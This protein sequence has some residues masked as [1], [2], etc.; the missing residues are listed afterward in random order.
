MSP[1]PKKRNAILI[2][3]GAGVFVVGTGLAAFAV[4]DSG[5]SSAPPPAVTTTTVADPDGVVAA[6]DAAAIA[7]P[8][9][10]PSG[11][12]AMSIQTSV[13]DG[14]SGYAKAGD[15]VNVYG[16]IG[17]PKSYPTEPGALQHAKLILQKVEVL[18]TTPAATGQNTMTFV[19]AVSTSDA[20]A[21]GYLQGFQGFYLTLA[22]DD[23]SSLTPNGFKTANA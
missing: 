20:E 14:M 16:V 15:F 3:V 1:A 22:R 8:F 5:G 10:I 17:Q 4:N 18:S 6:P 11:K 13:V 21:L 2:A 9:T 12:Q 19:L 7:Q 23:Q